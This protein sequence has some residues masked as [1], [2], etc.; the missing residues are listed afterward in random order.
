MAY[1]S[2]SLA[3]SAF[4]TILSITCSCCYLRRRCPGYCDWVL[5]STAGMGK[6]HD[7]LGPGKNWWRHTMAHV[8]TDRNLQAILHRICYGAG[9]SPP[10]PG[11]YRKRLR[12]RFQTVWQSSSGPN[13]RQADALEAHE[14]PLS[15]SR[16][17]VLRAHSKRYRAEVS[18]LEHRGPSRRSVD[19]TRWCWRPNTNLQEFSR[20]C[21]F[22]RSQVVWT[23]SGS[24]CSDWAETGFG[25]WDG[26][27]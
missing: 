5:L 6:W 12:N 25:C 10:L 7:N 26:P 23:N 19:P 2:H 20:S 22:T 16:Y 13:K 21:F 14:G 18:L 8:R 11:A 27:R 17:W 4:R 9:E 15:Q 3:Y 24:S 1:F